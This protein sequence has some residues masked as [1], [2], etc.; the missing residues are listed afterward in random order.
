MSHKKILMGNEARKAIKVGVDIVADATK[1]TLGASGRNVAYDRGFGGP[2][3]T[4][5]GVSIAREIVLKDQIENMGANFCKETSQRTNDAA[6]DGTTTSMVL[7]QAIL[8]EGL[9]KIDV[10]VSPMGIRKGIEKASKLAIGY[11]KSV[12]KPIKSDEETLQVAVISAESKEIG[13]MIAK[14][15]SKLGADS[16]ITIEESPLSGIT[17][18]ISQGMDF[19]KGFISHYMVTN[20]DRMES[21]VKDARILVTDQKIGDINSMV[22]I[23][24][25]LMSS[26][27]RELVIIAEDVVGECLQTFILN[28][29]RGVMTVLCIKAPGFGNR[30]R[31]YLE[32][33]SILTGAT[34]IAS[35]LG[36][37]LEDLTL[38]HLGTADRVVST[39]DKTVIVG[40]RGSQITIAERVASAKKEV[41]GLES[42]HD[43]LKVEE[44]IAKLTGGVAV[45]KV[46][47]AT[48]TET[49]YLKLKVEDAVAAVK[50]SLEEGIV[51]GGGIALLRASQF[52]VKPEDLTDDEEVGF[53]IVLKAL[54]APLRQIAINCG[55]GDGSSVVERV[56]ASKENINSG[57]DALKNVYS[58]DMI[59]DG[60]VDPVKVTRS[61]LENA[62]SSGGIILTLEVAIVEIK[63]DIKG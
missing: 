56:L 50:A 47:A 62:V 53:N 58:E 34:F 61:A 5:D 18:E 45:I 32:D 7:L 54:E 9:K 51:A 25:Q 4:N 33:I 1:I 23:M 55:I 15:V 60:I 19:D 48:E 52:I 59:K 12:A 17:S 14:T 21:E 38:E 63:E 16:V 40:G 36:I 28:T 49:K 31:D 37:K 41:E 10:G 27:K 24:D 30:K 57:Y 11:L 43:K 8:T 46:G 35:D 39:K 3:V 29:L 20:K 13:E 2:S 44:R 22:P 42:K 26:G 6:G